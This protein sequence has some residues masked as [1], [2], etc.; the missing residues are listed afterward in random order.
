MFKP[1]SMYI[2]LRYTKAKRDNNFISFI[3]LASV[4]GIALGVIVLSQAG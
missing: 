4:I 1:L 3:S 2:G